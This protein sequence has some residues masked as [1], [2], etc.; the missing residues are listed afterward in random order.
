MKQKS[1]VAGLVV[2]LVLSMLTFENDFVNFR[3]NLPQN[4]LEIN[5]L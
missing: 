1:V 5:F 2:V 4:V 3:L